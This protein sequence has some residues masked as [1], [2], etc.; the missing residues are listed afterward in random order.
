MLAGPLMTDCFVHVELRASNTAG[1]HVYFF[2]STDPNILNKRTKRNAKM[3][4]NNSSL[5]SHSVHDGFLVSSKTNRQGLLWDTFS[6][7]TPIAQKVV[8]R[9]SEEFKL[10]SLSVLMP[11]NSK[12]D[13]LRGLAFGPLLEIM[14]VNT[15]GPIPTYNTDQQACR[16]RLAE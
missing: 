1:P 10:R 13:D 9:L 14:H 6:F 12:D 7:S 4:L 11:V 8:N 15:R 3:K 5:A 16:R 2:R